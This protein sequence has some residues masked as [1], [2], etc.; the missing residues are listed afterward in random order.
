MI[1][2]PARLLTVRTMRETPL[3]LKGYGLCRE[4]H[5]LWAV[6]LLILDFA[7]LAA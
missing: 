7:V 1:Q 6:P 4:R 2:S 5:C 3:D